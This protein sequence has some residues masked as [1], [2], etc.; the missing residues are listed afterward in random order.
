MGD[1]KRTYVYPEPHKRVKL[2]CERSDKIDRLPE[3]YKYIVTT[4]L[5]SGE[6]S[7]PSLFQKT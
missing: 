1:K 7:D 2:F 6:G 3:A 4:V 5:D